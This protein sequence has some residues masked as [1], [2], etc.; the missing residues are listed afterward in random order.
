MSNLTHEQTIMSSNDG[1]IT[2]TT[3]RILQRSPKFNKEMMLADFISYEQVNGKSR[4]YK[5]L[6]LIFLSLAII[7]GFVYNNK[8][9]DLETLRGRFNM[10][11]QSTLGEHMS[12]DEQIQL[13]QGLFVLFAVLLG[14][15]LLLFLS[16]SSRSLKITG[17]FSIIEFST[18]WLR[19]T[20]YSKFLN[21]IVTESDKRK[22]EG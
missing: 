12:I 6:T 9:H 7:F 16:S 14:I 2:L 19:D 10:A 4:Y 8:L 15:S 5:T 22:R 20:S 17:K 1:S 13:Y 11:F 18:K 3:H 21:A